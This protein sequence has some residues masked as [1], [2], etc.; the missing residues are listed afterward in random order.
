M[1]QTSPKQSPPPEPPRSKPVILYVE[2]DEDN[3]DVAALRL[4]PHYELLHAASAERACAMLREHGHRLQLIMMDIELRGSDLSGTELA[5]LW[6]GHL[7]ATTTLPAYAR[8]LPAVT[9][10]IL[11]VTAHSTQHDLVKL[12]LSSGEQVISK[13]VDFKELMTALAKLA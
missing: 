6:R 7:P 11:F 8:D 1:R 2:D 13:P 9:R 12:M 4:G 10:P 3:W 5:Q